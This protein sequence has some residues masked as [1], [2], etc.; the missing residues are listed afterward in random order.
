MDLR[1]YYMTIDQVAELF[2][3]HRKTIDRWSRETPGFPPKVTISPRCVRF[4][5]DEVVDFM[6]TLGNTAN[7]N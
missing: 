3:V 2:C 5:T 7:A 6:R 4:R 1:S